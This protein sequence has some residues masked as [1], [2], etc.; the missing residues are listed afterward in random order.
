MQSLHAADLMS[1]L[2]REQSQSQ[3]TELPVPKVSLYLWAPSPLRQEMV[4][5]LPLSRPVLLCLLLIPLND[6]KKVVCRA[7]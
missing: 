4:N 1:A 5:I 7:N 2:F 3:E 6:Y